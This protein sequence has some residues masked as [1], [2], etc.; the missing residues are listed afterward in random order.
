MQLD[1]GCF[2]LLLLLF[3]FN[4]IIYLEVSVLFL[5]DFSCFDKSLTF[6]TLYLILSLLLFQFLYGKHYVSVIQ[7]LRKCHC[8]ITILRNKRDE[9][10]GYVSTVG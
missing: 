5:L 1:H 9:L 10:Q 3:C 8:H 6:G 7:T 4:L 2:L